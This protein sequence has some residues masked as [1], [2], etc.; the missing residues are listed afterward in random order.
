MAFIHKL[1]DTENRG[2]C[3]ALER[4]GELDREAF[5][6]VYTSISPAVF[7]IITRIVGFGPSAELALADVF[8][9]LHV[10]GAMHD[11]KPL[12]MALLLPLVF[13]CAAKALK[14]VLSDEE[15]GARIDAE[16][17][18]SGLG[19]GRYVPRVVG[20]DEVSL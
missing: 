18:R 6:L 5:H 10:Q 1:L 16:R 4:L 3:D 9:C 7:G 12:G 17:K 2:V 13:Q 20:A 19:M 14:G 11:G 8:L 15:I